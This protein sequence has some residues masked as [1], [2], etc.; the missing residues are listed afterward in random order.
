MSLNGE[1]GNFVNGSSAI[2][3]SADGFV[4]IALGLV[5]ICKDGLMIPWTGPWYLKDDKKNLREIKEVLES[6]TPEQKRRIDSLRDSSTQSLETLLEE[7]SSYVSFHELRILFVKNNFTQ[8][9][10]TV[11]RIC[12]ST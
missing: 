11:E 6:I 5:L 12:S 4:A 7:Y 9:S 2:F 1:F 3:G 10:R 8:M